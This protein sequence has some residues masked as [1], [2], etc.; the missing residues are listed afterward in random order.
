MRWA[1]ESASAGERKPTTA[2]ESSPWME[3]LASA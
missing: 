2:P 1:R 3:S